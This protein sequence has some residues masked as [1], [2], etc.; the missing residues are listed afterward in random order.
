MKR[1]K[2]TPKLMLENCKVASNF[3]SGTAELSPHCHFND[4]SKTKEILS[5]RKVDSLL[6]T[7]GSSFS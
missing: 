5:I 6:K 2:L 4:I 3:I 1:I 7:D